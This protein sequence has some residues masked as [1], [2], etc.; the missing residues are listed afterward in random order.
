MPYIVKSSL[1]ISGKILP[2]NE[3]RKTYKRKRRIY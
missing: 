2:W 1:D 3:T